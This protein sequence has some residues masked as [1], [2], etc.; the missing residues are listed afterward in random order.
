MHNQLL[1]PIQ[2]AQHIGLSKEF[3]ARDRCTD[4]RIPFIK[5]G[6][7][8][9]RY[10]QEDLDAFVESRVTTSTSAYQQQVQVARA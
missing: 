9:V 8:T 7:R 3:L 1:T 4:A 5:L 10:R 6:H 2:A